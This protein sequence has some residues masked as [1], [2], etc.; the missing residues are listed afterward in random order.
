MSEALYG[1]MAEFDDAE[2][3]L[4]AVGRLRRK[5]PAALLEAYSP[6]PVA[7]LEEQLA[8]HVDHTPAWTLLGGLL[9]GLGTFAIEWYSAVIDY[10]IQVGGRP[11]GSWQ[12]FL[13][14]AIEMTVLGA[15]LFGV[16][17]MLVA[18]RLPMV[19]HPLFGVPAFERASSDR[20]FLLIRR[21]DA[22]FNAERARTALE[23]LE[24]L[25]VWDVPT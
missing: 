8:R 14:P 7:G 4:A 21:L 18:S 6:F 22:H 11:T 5:M 24:P 20:F 19:R 25:A 23:A 10:P 12:A 9:G 2:A 13:P 3:L 15:A 1:L 16:L 17:A